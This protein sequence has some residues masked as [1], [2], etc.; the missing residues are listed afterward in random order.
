MA[1]DIRFIIDGAD[2]GQPLNADEFGF[3]ITENVEINARIVS[4]DNDLIFSGGVYQYLFGILV[5]TGGCELLDVKVE[6]LCAGSW[7]KL[8]DG[9]IIISECSYDIDKCQVKTKI[10]D[11]SFSTKINN[12]KAVPF[13]LA[14]T[15]TKNLVPVVAPT[16]IKGKFFNPPTGIYDTEFIYGV[17]LF[18]AF[19]HLITCMS[20][21]LI[22]FASDL[23]NFDAAVSDPSFLLVTNGEAIFNR[24]KNETVVSFES[25]YTAMKKKLN[26]G[27]QFEKQANGRP[28]LRIEEA[29]YFF[30][31]TPSVNLYDQP[32]IDLRFDTQSQ[33]AAINFGGSP[34]LEEFQCDSGNTPCT[35][36]Q[37]SF[38][39]FKEET[40]GMTGKCNVS[41]VLELSTSD[42]VFDTNV[43]E[44]VYRFNAEDYRTSTFIIDS[45]YFSSFPAQYQANQFDPYGTGQTVYNGSLTNDNVAVNWIGGYPN[46]IFNFIQGFVPGS[47][48]FEAQSNAS[49]LQDWDVADDFTSY[50]DLTG[51][52]VQFDNEVID[53]SNNFDGQTYT[54]PYTGTY[55]FTAQFLLGIPDPMELPREAYASIRRYNADEVLLSYFNGV[56]AMDVVDEELICSVTY[57]VVCNEGDRIRADVWGRT[58]GIVPG[59]QMMTIDNT[60]GDQF[61]Y[62][63]GIGQPFPNELQA[64]DPNS[65]RRIL[66]K[67]E[68]P[69]TMGEIES[70]LSNTSKPITF[71]RY[72]DPLRVIPG[73][74]KTLTVNSLIKQNAAIELKSNKI[75]R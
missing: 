59:G 71:G 18:D 31:Q 68:R 41:T 17:S 4:F 74:I 66:Y 55:T 16:P 36:N 27:I 39:G 54:I 1:V 35:F 65:I 51:T 62:F 49:P 43:I 64:V 69:L 8:V 67:F 28:L 75:L 72:D 25:L 61:T 30:E 47:T 24:G 26:L 13:S 45:Y 19:K 48:Q 37:S 3:A 40:F 2:R 20:D 21:G 42:V 46:G 33:Y 11:E 22:D 58:D 23:L 5:D 32:S 14:C 34:F 73:Y 10:Y 63:E 38:K 29:S 9:Y 52:F 6:Y 60:F 70:I 12:N 53:V 15:F 44:D 50:R 56:I 57:V 7:K